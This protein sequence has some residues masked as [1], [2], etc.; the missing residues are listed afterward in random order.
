MSPGLPE[1]TDPSVQR[2]V[3]HLAHG[4]HAL[5]RLAAGA[6]MLD[7]D[8]QVRAARFRRDADRAL[9]RAAH[10]LLRR[11]LSRE[12][13]LPAAQWRFVRGAH[14]RPEIDTS[15]CPAAAGLRF[16]LAHTRGLVSCALTWHQPV[17]VDVECRREY[18]DVRAIAQR[19][20]AAEEARAVAAA[21]PPGS[22]AEATAFQGLWTLKEAYVKA[23][24][25]GLA[26]GLD[27]FAFRLTQ[28]PPARILL[29]QN[30][31]ASPCAGSAAHAPA[32]HWRCLLLH[33]DGGRCAVAAAVLAA[34]GAE[35]QVF[36]HDAPDAP[37][38]T[39][40]A[41]SPRARLLMG[42]P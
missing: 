22:V 40:V 27:G 25:L 35:L 5:A 11:A 34:D 33:L 4:G 2:V 39:L 29:R 15:A 26:M 38:P 6:A 23:H 21:G 32:H 19:F 17:G 10:V 14:G 7:P 37:R 42:R 31:P 16:N 12:V 1:A 18:R 24:G 13:A 3:L 9:Y 8:E 20:F 41:R 28:G 36:C 30:G